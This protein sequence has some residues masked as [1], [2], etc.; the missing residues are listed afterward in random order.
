MDI[1]RTTLL[2]RDVAQSKRGAA[3]ALLPLVY[4]E[5]KR[6]AESYFRSQKVSHTLQATAVVHE[7]FLKLVDQSGASWQD[8]NHFVAVAAIAM[9]QILVDHAL[10]K[11][12]L[13]RGGDR[14]RV[15]MEAAEGLA[16]RSGGVGSAEEGLDVLAVHTALEDLTKVD[17]RKARLVELRF[18]GG[19]EVEQAAL[20]LGVSRSTAEADWRF[21]RAWL[22]RR[23]GPAG[24]G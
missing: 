7:A 22:K 24:R 14:A 3:E 12:A 18:F 10:A 20:V 4:D 15:S 9:R 19:L 5:L 17:A 2:L 16:E 6:L 13:K 23:I 21:A 8:R 1:A 11:Q